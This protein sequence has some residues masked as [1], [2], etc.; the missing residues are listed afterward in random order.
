[1]GSLNSRAKKAVEEKT[2]FLL[3]ILEHSIPVDIFLLILQY[4]SEPLR[5]V[6]YI[7][8]NPMGYFQYNLVNIK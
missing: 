5:W 7:C 4:F 8:A 3:H 2:L 6:I 1:M